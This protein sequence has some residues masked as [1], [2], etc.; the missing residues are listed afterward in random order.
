MALLVELIGHCDPAIPV[1]WQLACSS[2][3][4]MRR[5]PLCG[6]TGRLS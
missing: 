6:K 4:M 1:A 2:L 3:E 5:E